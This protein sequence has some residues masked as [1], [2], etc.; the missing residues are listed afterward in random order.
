MQNSPDE[1]RQYLRIDP[2]NLNA[3]DNLGRTPL[4]LASCHSNE[5]AARI[6]LQFGAD[7]NIKD[8]SIRCPL[9]YAAQRS[10]GLVQALIVSSNEEQVARL[11]K[12]NDV[13]GRNA[14]YFAIEFNRSEIFSYLCARGV[15]LNVKDGLQRTLL[16]YAAW[17]GQAEVMDVMAQQD[18]SGIDL[19]ALDNY[20]KT[21]EQCF[22]SLRQDVSHVTIAAFQRLLAAAS[23]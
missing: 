12:A 5:D 1:L 22:A 13:R 23:S 21:A 16:H 4:I 2:T 20:G 17:T 18:L 3:Q 6:L 7:P 14:L 9:H 11:L 8:R 10:L 19:M 15:S